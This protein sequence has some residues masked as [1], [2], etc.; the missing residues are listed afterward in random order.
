MALKFKSVFCLA[1]LAVVVF[2]VTSA[3]PYKKRRSNKAF[4]KRQAE[5]STTLPEG[6]ALND[7][8]LS[9]EPANDVLKVDKKS[10]EPQS[11]M[12]D[13]PNESTT[14]AKPKKRRRGATKAKEESRKDAETRKRRYN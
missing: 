7:E 3:E 14:T 6:G 2:A 10:A 1:I 5:S 13:E 12:N 11:E 4:A 8:A 9:D